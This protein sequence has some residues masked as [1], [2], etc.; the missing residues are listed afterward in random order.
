MNVLDFDRDRDLLKQFLEFPQRLHASDPNWLPDPSE[1]RLLTDGFSSS[2]WRNFL[3][4]H[5]GEIKG[6]ATAIINPSLRDEQDQPYGQIGFFDCMDDLSAA[7][8][9]VDGALAWLKSKLG[10]KATVFAPMNFDT[11]HPYRLRAKGFDQP[12]FLMEPYNPP[13]YPALLENLGFSAMTRYVTKTV[14]D[15]EP[16]LNVWREFHSRALSQGYSI[17]SFNL[18]DVAAEISSVYRLS[19]EMFNENFYYTDISESEFRA[20]YAGAAGRLDPDLFLFILD[21]QR[22]PVGFCFSFADHRQPKTVNVKTFGVLPHVRGEGVGAALA[23]EAYRRFQAKGFL[24]ANH[25]LLREGN[26]ADKFDGG[27][28]AVTREYTLYARPTQ[29]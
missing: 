19:T 22:N 6:R 20:L 17:R 10:E 1:E 2:L 18:A 16:S 21:P 27:L 26:R 12:T 11:W 15:L 24:R 9:L 5:G 7:Q 3:V 8:L 28:G 14:D 25:C 4:L 29:P 23:Y 13:Y